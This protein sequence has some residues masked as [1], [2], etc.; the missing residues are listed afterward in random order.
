[1]S[2]QRQHQQDSA[3][4]VRGSI[5]L[6]CAVLLLVGGA[7]LMWDG[8]IER[9][10]PPRVEFPRRMTDEHLERAN[11]RLVPMAPLPPMPGQEEEET[12][13][14]EQPEPVY[15]D[16][17]LDALAGASSGAVVMEVSAFRHS[18]LGNRVVSCVQGP[19]REM[20][21]EIH[22]ATGI[23]FIEDLD[24]V[25]IFVDGGLP[26]MLVSG[27]FPRGAWDEA[28]KDVSVVTERHGDAV[29]YEL[30]QEPVAVW[31]D[32][33]V[34]FG[35][36]EEQ[37]RR[38]IDLLEGRATPENRPLSP[39]HT[40]GEMYGALTKEMLVEL[41]ASLDPDL[42]RQTEELLTS[43]RFNLSAS[44]DVGLVGALEATSPEAAADL[45][46]L[47]AGGLSV[48]RTAARR[49]GDEK[50]ADL[51]ELARVIPGGRGDS[52]FRIELALPETYLEEWV[53]NFCAK[54]EAGSDEERF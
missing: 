52:L 40:Y 37:I 39:E 4:R 41:L 19:L 3:K 8:R 27:H 25:A 14:L 44:G 26:G 46:R 6:V 12:D 36:N 20:L 32:Q 51:L 18:P 5:W 22:E 24:R 31:R 33:F 47:L 28:L 30:V 17:F 2:P 29:I 48:A 38:R 10:D 49:H 43:A 11:V 23:D 13:D 9:P 34:L 54:L 53:S 50:F 7:L 45:S 21:D 1:M 42:A 16:P 35:E 15:R